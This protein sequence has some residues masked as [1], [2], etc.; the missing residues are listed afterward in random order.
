MYKLIY[1][2]R[3]ASVYSRH[4][5]RNTGV[6]QILSIE[7]ITSGSAVDDLAGEYVYWDTTFNSRILIDFN[8]TAISASISANSVSNPTFYLRLKCTEAVHLPLSYTIYAYPI[9]S[10][11]TNG[12]GFYNNNPQ[13]TNG[14][15]WLYRHG[16][17]DNTA[18][19]EAG[20]DFLSGSGQVCSQS[21]DYEKPD[22]FMDVT[23][24]VRLWMSGSL[25]K[26]GFML[27]HSTNVENDDSVVG[28]L[29][30]FSKD[31]HTI[32]V[33]RLE[34]Y[35]DNHENSGTSSL[36][37]ASLDTCV[38]YVKNLRSTY[39]E[40]EIAKVRI[41]VREKYPTFTYITSSFYTATKRLPA[42]AYY[43]IKDVATDEIIVPYHTEGTK[44]SCDTSGNYM[45]VDMDTLMPERFYKFTFKVTDSTESEIR[46]IDD[47]FVFKVVR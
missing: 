15:S 29:K 31:T 12:T 10:S 34:C 40:G 5:E 21:F 18:W 38:V 14:V 7:K 17:L 8:I 27:K 6:D 45:K 22:I 1:P 26:H 25:T 47:N 19:R 24:I 43:Q 46:F 2:T 35:W 3:D 39:K 20:G 42:T 9:S 44:L 33:P 37:E 30:F 4:P 32:Y 23:P 16:T 13:V 36:S 28:Q 41:G 11:W